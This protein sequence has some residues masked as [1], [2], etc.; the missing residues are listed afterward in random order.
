MPAPAFLLASAFRVL[1]FPFDNGIWLA[2]GEIWPVLWNVLISALWL[3]SR[4]YSLDL[5]LSYCNAYSGTFLSASHCVF[6][7]TCHFWNATPPGIC[8]LGKLHVLFSVWVI[9]LWKRA[10]G[11]E[12]HSRA[13][14]CETSRG[15]SLSP[16]QSLQSWPAWT[17]TVTLS[18]L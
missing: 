2:D 18:M 14:C 17:W 13:D 16:W 15:S 1:V 4:I 9:A 3:V 11:V 7:E 10:A 8:G 12:R 6:I 5:L